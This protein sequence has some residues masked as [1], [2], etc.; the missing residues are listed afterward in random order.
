MQ[1]P[2]LL[3]ADKNMNMLG[4]RKERKIILA[5]NMTL[6]LLMLGETPNHYQPGANQL[7]VSSKTD[8]SFFT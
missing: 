5:N 1:F 4:W 3:L 6:A 2:T 8:N 7:Q